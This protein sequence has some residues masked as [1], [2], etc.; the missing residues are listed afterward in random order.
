MSAYLC[1]QL[2]CLQMTVTKRPVERS[3]GQAIYISEENHRMILVGRNIK[4][5]SV[6][7]PPCLGQ[8][9]L[10]LDQVA[11]CPIQADLEHLL[12]FSGQLFPVPHQPLRNFLLIPNLIY[13]FQFKALMPSPAST[14][15]GKA[16]FSSFSVGSVMYWSSQCGLPTPLSSAD[17]KNSL[18]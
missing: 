4:Y 12:N 13:W 17:W 6:S 15:R 2:H 16:S 14:I 5:H 3:D 10:L 8:G 11:L 1:E 9:N 18:Q 7:S